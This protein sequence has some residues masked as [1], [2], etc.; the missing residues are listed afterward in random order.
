MFVGLCLVVERRR[1]DRGVLQWNRYRWGRL[2]K[3]KEDGAVM[4]ADGLIGT[5]STEDGRATVPLLLQPLKM[6]D[7]AV[8]RRSLDVL[9]GAVT[10]E[11][12]GVVG[13]V[14]DGRR[15]D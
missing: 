11:D 6:S 15:R 14:E 12:E 4:G 9:G 2:V 5:E 1:A 13:K 10:A 7:V 3:K 8:A